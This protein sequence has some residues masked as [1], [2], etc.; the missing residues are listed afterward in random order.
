MTVHFCLNRSTTIQE[1][2]LKRKEDLCLGLGPYSSQSTFIFR[3][4]PAIAT[5]AIAGDPGFLAPTAALG[6]TAW[7]EEGPALKRGIP[8]FVHGPK[9]PMLPPQGL[10]ALTLNAAEMQA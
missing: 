10:K 9:R 3:P 5:T 6:M 8:I 1:S 4:T 7:M 2:L